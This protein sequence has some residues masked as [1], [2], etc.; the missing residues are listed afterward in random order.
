MFDGDEAQVRRDHE[1]S[2]VLCDAALVYYGSASELW[3][4]QK[5]REITKSAGMGRTRPLAAKAVYVA[6]P[7]TPQKARFRTHEALVLTENGHFDSAVLAPFL[8]PLGG[9]TP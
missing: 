2:L 5:L 1:E 8:A 9:T 3:L 6:P 7:A 4:R